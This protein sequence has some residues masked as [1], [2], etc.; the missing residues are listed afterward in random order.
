MPIDQN[1]WLAFSP[2]EREAIAW[3]VLG[4]WNKKQFARYSRILRKL[5]EQLL[6]LI[7]EEADLIDPS[8]EKYS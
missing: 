6:P 4:S 3:C 7:P 8:S 2:E 1:P 5:E